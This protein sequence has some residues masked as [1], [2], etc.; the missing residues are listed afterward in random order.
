M[1]GR[2]VTQTI[3]FNF[4]GDISNLR[5]SIGQIEQKMQNIKLPKVA[6][7]GINS[8]LQKLKTELSKLESKTKGGIIKLDDTSSIQRSGERIK[9]LYTSLINKV[10]D[11]GNVS[12]KELKN[13][14]PPEIAQK[15]DKARAAM[16]KYEKEIK[17]TNAELRKQEKELERLQGVRDK[18]KAEF[19]I[20]GSKKKIGE[21]EYDDLTR[22]KKYQQGQSTRTKNQIDSMRAQY[23]KLAEKAG[24][25]K[26]GTINKRGL[27]DEDK[28]FAKD[29]EGLAIRAQK[30]TA[31]VEKLNKK[32]NESIKI[33]K[34]N[35]LE[36]E[37]NESEQQAK[38]AE[39]AVTNL[40]NKINQSFINFKGSLDLGIDSSKLQDIKAVE[41]AINS[42][43]TEEIDR[44]R[45]GFDGLGI[46]VDELESKV[47]DTG[48][49]ISGEFS[50]AANSAMSMRNQF[51]QLS[52]N[53][54]YFFG[55]ANGIQLFKRTIHEALQTVKELDAAMVKIAVVSD[56][57][58]SDMWSTLPEFTKR[59]NELGVAITEVYD[60]TGLY[61]QQGLDLVESQ[62]LAN[63]TLKMAKIAGMD[64]AAATDA[65]TSALR[66]F[67]MELNQGSAERVNDIYSKLAAITASDT[68]EIATA[69][70]KTAS[71]ANNAGA[72]IENTSAFLSMIIET[73]RESA[74]TAGT[75]LKTVIARFSEL[76]KNPAEIGSVEGEIVDANQI[77]SALRLANVDLRDTT[78]QFRNFDEV[79]IELS[80]KWD[81]LD[82]NTQRY[83]A[84]MAAGS[85]Q[86]SRFLAL[87]SDNE[88]LAQLTDAAYNSA[89][90]STTQFNKTLDSLESKMNQLKNAWNTFTQN[91]ANNELIKLGI[92]LLTGI[93]TAIN[94]ISEAFSSLGSII[95]S[96]LSTTMV[97][98]FFTLAQK[99]VNALLSGISNGIG[100]FG[101]KIQTKM[102]EITNQSATSGTNAGNQFGENFTNNA[103]TKINTF[104]DNF[105][106]KTRQAEGEIA[107]LLPQTENGTALSG[108]EFRRERVNSVDEYFQAKT[109]HGFGE[110]KTVT[111]YYN[112]KTR[113]FKQNED[114]T[115][116]FKNDEGKNEI[117]D[118]FDNVTELEPGKL[119]TDYQ[120]LG[121]A[122]SWAGAAMTGLGVATSL[123]A[124][125]LRKNGNEEAAEF[126]EKLGATISL[127]GSLAVI[128][129]P[130][131]S[132]FGDVAKKAGMKA[133]GKWALLVA[134]I[135]LLIFGVKA[136]VDAFSKNTLEGRLT[137]LTKQTEKAAEAAQKA[138]EAYSNWLSDKNEYTGLTEALK[139]LTEGTN[140]WSEQMDKIQDKVYELVNTYPELAQYIENGQIT[141]EGLS[142]LDE[143]LKKQKQIAISNKVGLQMEKDELQYQKDL[144]DLEKERKKSEDPDKDDEYWE[145]R[146]KELETNYNKSQQGN[147][148]YLL[149][150][151]GVE[152]YLA[153]NI[154]AV[155]TRKEEKLLPEHKSVGN[156][157]KTTKTIGTIGMGAA[158]VTAGT[159]LIGGMAAAITSAG[160]IAALT[161][162]GT[163]AGTAIA[164]GVTGFLISNPV[165]WVTAGVLVAGVL[166][167]GVAAGINEWKNKKE[168]QEAYAEMLG[169]DV[170]ELSD[171]IK[172]NVEQMTAELDINSKNQV[173]IRQAQILDAKISTLG[174]EVRRLFAGD[175]SL[176]SELWSQDG[177]FEKWKQEVLNGLGDF[178]EYGEYAF[179]Q[180]ENKVTEVQTKIQKTFGGKVKLDFEVG[181]AISMDLQQAADFT[182]AQEI[183]STEFGNG[184]VS[185]M[186][187]IS[188]QYI[189][190]DLALEK[191]TNGYIELGKAANTSKAQV[192]ALANELMKSGDAN[193]AIV[194]S[195]FLAAAGNSVNL[196]NQFKDFYM[197]LTAEQLNE[198]F[199]N[200]KATASVMYELKES[201]AD[202][203]AMNKNTNV[204]FAT[205]AD[206]MNNLRSGILNLDDVTGDFIKTL[207]D[208]NKANHIIEDAMAEAA[209]FSD[210]ESGEIIGE[211]S[212]SAA[213]KLV[214]IWQNERFADPSVEKYIDFLFGAGEWEEALKRNKYNAKAAMSEYM[215]YISKLSEEENYFD[216][217]VS[218]A[219]ESGGL[220]SVQGDAITFNLDG[221]TDFNDLVDK[222]SERTGWTVK[223]IEK[224]L[225]DAQ[226]WSN[227]LNQSL[228][229]LN[230]LKGLNDYIK[231]LEVFS[232]DGEKAIELNIEQMKTIYESG[233]DAFVDT[234][235]DFYAI[236]ENKL[237]SAGYKISK[238]GENTY[239]EDNVYSD[240]VKENLIKTTTEGY[241]VNE[242]KYSGDFIRASKEELL[243]KLLEEFEKANPN[244]DL[245]GKQ[246]E[247]L[248]EAFSKIIVDEGGQ[249]AIRGE[250]VG[251]I[252]NLINQA[253]NDA[254]SEDGVQKDDYI[255]SKITYNEAKGTAIFFSPTTKA[256]TEERKN[257]YRG[258][259]SDL[260]AQYYDETGDVHSATEKVQDYM[261]EQK[262]AESL[263]FK[264]DENGKY[265][266]KQTKE[267][268]EIQNIL[269][270]EMS[271]WRTEQISAEDINLT[272][273]ATLINNGTL[274]AAQYIVAKFGEMGAI[275]KYSADKITGT[276]AAADLDWWLNRTQAQQDFKQN[277]GK[278]SGEKT[279]VEKE[280]SNVSVNASDIKGMDT[281]GGTT[282]PS[283]YTG[284]TDEE[285]EKR[286]KSIQASLEQI[287]FDWMH[288]FNELGEKITRTLDNLST[289]FELA[290]KTLSKSSK[291][292][293]Q[294]LVE[295]YANMEAEAVV[296]QAKADAAQKRMQGMLAKNSDLTK[297]TWYEDG[298][299][300]INYDKINADKADY[301]MTEKTSILLDE[302]VSLA[303]V[304]NENEQ[305]Q[306]DVDMKQ[307][308]FLE[309]ITN[310]VIDFEN[311]VRDMVI[312]QYEQEIDKLEQIDSAINDANSKL[313][314]SIQKSID[315]YRQDRDNE[316]TE[317]DIE[318]K[319][320][321]LA[322]L[323]ADTSSA[324][325]GEIMSLEKEIGEAQEDYTDTLIDQKISALQEQN[326][327]ASAQRQEQI[328]IANKQLKSAKENGLINEQVRALLDKSDTFEGSPLEELWK[329]S[330]GLKGYDATEWDQQLKDF[331]E[332][333]LDYQANNSFK[334]AYMAGN[335]SI[336]ANLADELQK[337]IPNTTD[338]YSTVQDA[339]GGYGI[340]SSEEKEKI[341]EAIGNT[342]PGFNLDDYK[343]RKVTDE[344]SQYDSGVYYEHEW[345]EIT[346][347]GISFI[348]L[349]QGG[350][351]VRKEDLESYDTPLGKRWRIKKN[352]QLYKFA[353]GGL[354]TQT[355]P[356]WLDGTPS[357]PELVLNAQD[358]QNFLQL[359]D[360]L[361]SIM[362]NGAFS[363][364]PQNDGTINLEI[365]LNVEQG[366]SSD[367]DVEQLVT[368]VKQEIARVGQERNIQ[369]LTKR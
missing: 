255:D 101:T 367:Y 159:A 169:V 106:Q 243:N 129:G 3:K 180:I 269:L 167:A 363:T 237:S 298:M 197:N 178:K 26:D 190:S 51:D 281:S 203:G 369:I 98:A 232:I 265:T 33:S 271:T 213:E 41:A 53:I 368:K 245:S 158:G 328:D 66:G 224:M 96:V 182:Q 131:V 70:S 303:D 233:F 173:A 241:E 362:S 208:L 270:S 181:T 60:A 95:G 256:G 100:Q 35:E 301:N 351:Y 130:L 91:L 248:K 67:N 118:N 259:F 195:G 335:D 83:I 207:D 64:A 176:Y 304:I 124:Q 191:L 226:I 221:I 273:Q 278:A 43:G 56:Y 314:N 353:T 227:E 251:Y 331:K 11:L 341:L 322:L 230:L 62:G 168:I 264:A 80:S 321:R 128:A 339:L 299:V 30:A 150:S 19:K 282:T 333:Y 46:E 229:Q 163:A 162:L 154:A 71:I 228:T 268:K 313:I 55:I 68:Q 110:Y 9:E 47:S 8:D 134:V 151:A 39:Q 189:D 48:E 107:R 45:Q 142:V 54:Q 152:G 145:T 185:V 137:S 214:N 293:T 40:R 307:A 115:Y 25:N 147:Y 244:I 126:F 22:Q 364:T 275:K 112:G 99:G 284:L 358:T 172:N 12:D 355:G 132:K 90:A 279:T 290:V 280:T 94:G 288:N 123:V 93:L 2:Q 24:I 360:I 135:S 344:Y 177:G 199:K 103:N 349:L 359:K 97:I 254:F 261:S 72:S 347:Q 140:A 253:V 171:D 141:D 37:L 117:I 306:L 136:L 5:G 184:V 193:K 133:M 204:S 205:L 286:K 310:T 85:R 220:W 81:G 211:K 88:R 146:R 212:A 179:E 28:Q 119:Q 294:N 194:G 272:K 238:E 250:T 87:M 297:Y 108:E 324:N 105:I 219:N 175:L 63:K 342:N 44:L 109:G 196:T 258:L 311:Q 18:K 38:E 121:D 312:E 21:E 143:K 300:K 49:K 23:N 114:G 149:Q 32:I 343:T 69:M 218:K 166:V 302:L 332:K 319:Q 263:G 352:A 61:V 215:D 287:D 201:L 155:K 202:V 57:D 34:Y 156:S 4:E 174:P 240:F 16:D 231:G 295:Q 327:E 14:F 267:I 289:E 260:F 74:E 337:V 338:L 334:S 165:G 187:A 104:F 111:G 10:K 252:Q 139:D 15:I 127:V 329:K 345:N 325:R 242:L 153:E 223:A 320:R 20:A 216:V 292:L 6:E 164:S 73:T 170:D 50:Q 92:D 75:A 76:K 84:T 234:F 122:I 257:E 183:L 188:K 206:I 235:E 305:T 336:N 192:V 365:Y 239:S 65:M 198:V 157:Y 225:A 361:S 326:E 13:L 354:N 222:I 340:M 296:S 277:T 346:K 266:E 36:K 148:S 144:K 42:I 247:A 316:K 78:G 350:E 7:K 366:L 52:A 217:W 116:S 323:R 246:G 276:G 236:A 186:D 120:K 262:I 249:Y 82:K 27:S 59:A 283:S 315:R 79:I 17:E 318:D 330:N 160:G 86:Q 77:E 102:Q 200:G 29:Y 58:M 356:A 1:A 309:E 161:G 348:S 291:E 209:A 89:G 274:T 210:P 125:Q 357:K 113:T 308:E 317:K 31:E 285:I 138:Q